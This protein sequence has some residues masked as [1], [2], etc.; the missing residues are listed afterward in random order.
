MSYWESALAKRTITRRRALLAAGGFAAGGL[1]LSLVGCG[2]N[3][4]GGTGSTSTIQKPEDSTEKAVRGGT[5][6]THWPGDESNLDPA[7]TRRSLGMGGP[8]T[9]GYSRLI[10]EKAVKGGADTVEWVAD[11]AQSYELLPDGTTLALKLRPDARFDPREPTNGRAV[12]ADDVVF[13]WQRWSSLSPGR[14]LL[15]NSLNP[16]AGLVSISK[17]DSTTVQA[18]TAFPWRGLMPS[19][20]ASGLFVV[21]VEADGKFDIRNTMRGTGP[22][23]LEEYRQSSLFRWKRNPNYFV[24]EWP[25]LDGFDQPILTE[26][27]AQLSQF[28]AKNL[29]QLRPLLP[30]NVQQLVRDLPAIK[31]YLTTLAEGNNMQGIIFGKRTA[32]FRDARVR[33]AVSMSIDRALVAEVLSANDVLDSEGLGR[34]VYVHSHVSPQFSGGVWLDPLGKALGDA[35]KFFKFDIAE[36]KKLLS[37]AG[38]PNGLDVQATVSSQSHGAGKQSEITH[39]MMNAAGIR[40][41]LRVADY[42]AEYLPKYRQSRG[43]FEGLS[44]AGAA[45]P[46]PDLSME[47]LRVWHSR[48][49]D[50]MSG[51]EDAAQAKIDSRIESL[52]KELDAEK[53][54]TAIHDFQREMAAHMGGVPYFYSAANYDLVWPWVQNWNV[55]RGSLI[56]TYTFRDRL[57]IDQSKRA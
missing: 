12:T 42:Q 22:W 7:T 50:T 17:V 24:K 52:G 1:A 26:T 18:K 45:A 35:A 32:E 9:P 8:E 28:R 47:L 10:R 15:I 29:D 49:D 23:M 31:V 3:E 13:S 33:Q 56:D 11:L 43:D 25:L 20:G 44:W 51:W 14:G 16:S 4:D 39:E 27:A 40:S 2:S 55:W 19:L 41:Q 46:A 6:V 53:F 30:E 21:P 34:D 38:H 48:S 36:A 57:W 5:L 54:K 37:A